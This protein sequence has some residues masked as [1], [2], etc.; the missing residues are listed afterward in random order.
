MFL[1][2]PLL[3]FVIFIVS[4]VLISQQNK[5]KKRIIELLSNENKCYCDDC[6]ADMCEIPKR[7]QVIEICK[8]KKRFVTHLEENCARCG[9]IKLT[10]S[11]IQTQ[12]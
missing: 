4:V 12:K 2:L 3:S 11:V 1:S 6:I 7:E 5:R 8:N 10:R 9:V